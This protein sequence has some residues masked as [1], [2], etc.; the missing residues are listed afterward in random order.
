MRIRFTPVEN[1][2]GGTLPQIMILSGVLMMMVLSSFKAVRT[3]IQ[4]AN[5]TASAAMFQDLVFAIQQDLADTDTCKDRL[6]GFATGPGLSALLLNTNAT[7]NVTVQT[8][9]GDIVAAPGALNPVN[10][11]DYSVDSIVL[12]NFRPFGRRD[13]DLGSP[14]WSG[15]SDSYIGEIV[16]AGSRRNEYL[17]ATG[18]RTTLP[19]VL[20]VTPGANPVPTSCT[21]RSLYAVELGPMPQVLKKSGLECFDRGG[22]PVINPA[23]GNFYVCALPNTTLLNCNSI[24]N[25]PDSNA[26]YGPIHP[27]GW[28]CDTAASNMSVSYAY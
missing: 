6:V 16:I 22:T 25:T 17:G 8:S 2:H 26:P 11:P 24:N 7:L 9:N 4:I 21:T 28:I 10:S 3:S 12:T 1:A 19:I 20:Q 27:E 15:F 5:T 23:I 14:S 18:L 13:S